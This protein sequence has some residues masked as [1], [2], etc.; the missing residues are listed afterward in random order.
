MGNDLSFL[1][2][3][4]IKI[5]RHETRNMNSQRTKCEKNVME[6]ERERER[7]VDFTVVARCES[8]EK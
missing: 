8:V 5:Y 2:S 4:L 1:K 3:K 7:V 6:R